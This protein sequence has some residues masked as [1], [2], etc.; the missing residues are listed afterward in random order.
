MQILQIV[1]VDLAD[2]CWSCGLLCR[3]CTLLFR[4]CRFCVGLSDC[5]VGLAD[6]CVGFADFVWALQILCRSYRFRVGLSGCCN[7]QGI[8]YISSALYWVLEVLC[9]LLTQ[10]LSNRSQHVTVDDCWSKLVNVVS[11][12]P[13]GFFFGPIIVPPVH[14]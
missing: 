10:F 13:Q 6:C 11:G 4:S 5:C 7:H 8:L 1:C 14:F 2:L 9:Y 3:S 12:V